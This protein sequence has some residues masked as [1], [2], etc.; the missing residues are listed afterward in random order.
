MTWVGYFAPQSKCWSAN[1]SVY[2]MRE[3]Q[4]R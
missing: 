2:N 4:E 3:Q 1:G